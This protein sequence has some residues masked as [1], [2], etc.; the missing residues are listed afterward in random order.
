MLNSKQE[1]TPS[2]LLLDYFQ[3]IL[4]SLLVDTWHYDE[5][6]FN[7]GIERLYYQNNKFDPSNGTPNIFRNNV[8]MIGFDLDKKRINVYSIYQERS[9]EDFSRYY[10]GLKA[11][12]EFIIKLDYENRD[13]LE[14]SNNIKEIIREELFHIS[15]PLIY[16]YQ[17]LLKRKTKFVES[18]NLLMLSKSD[19]LETLFPLLSLENKDSNLV[20]QH[21]K[22]AQSYFGEFEAVTNSTVKLKPIDRASLKQTNSFYP[23]SKEFSKKYFDRILS[24]FRFSDN[25]SKDSKI[26][27]ANLI[28]DQIDKFKSKTKLNLTISTVHEFVNM[29][30]MDKKINEFNPKFVKIIF[31]ELSYNMIKEGSMHLPSSFPDR[32]IS[33]GI[34][35][36]KLS[37]EDATKELINFM[38]AFFSNEDPLN[39]DIELNSNPEN[40]NFWNRI[41]RDFKTDDRINFQIKSY[42]TN[43]QI[44]GDFFLK[45]ETIRESLK[46]KSITLHPE[47]LKTLDEFKNRISIILNL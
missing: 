43:K 13:S 11:W 21:S 16:E 17:N 47:L 26:K 7:D 36:K 46:Q 45:D 6:F 41:S 18:L 35:N 12:D 42:K 27:V 3:T 34:N 40:F 8:T 14:F 5:V 22:I 29:M 25:F 2:S 38:L 4:K 1:K 20:I 28:M 9:T 44:P 37:E 30:V 15:S 32:V 23:I 39:C 24:N 10:Y 19:S 31:E 33:Y